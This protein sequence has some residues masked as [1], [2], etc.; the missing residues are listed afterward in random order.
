MS[1]RLMAIT[2]DVMLIALITVMTDILQQSKL[3]S[4]NSKKDKVRNYIIYTF[5]LQ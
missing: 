2:I 1:R 3:E 5:Y 4:F